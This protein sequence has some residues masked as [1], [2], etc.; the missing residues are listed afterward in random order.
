MAK[1]DTKVEGS[2]VG[3]MATGDGATASSTGNLTQQHGMDSKTAAQLATLLD[4]LLGI[5]KTVEVPTTVKPKLNETVTAVEEAKV[6][7]TSAAPEK[8]KLSATFDKVKGWVNGA[9]SVGMFA[10]EAAK[11]VG[12]LIGRVGGLLG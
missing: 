10:E 12:D 5:L 8:G 6:I 1:Y 11:K 4:E 7:A 3:A 9:L 2:Q